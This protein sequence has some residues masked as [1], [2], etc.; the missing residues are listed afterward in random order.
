MNTPFYLKV[1]TPSVLHCHKLP[2][3]CQ[4][5][6]HLCERIGDS[7]IILELPWL[8]RKMFNR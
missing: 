4:N 7:F 1:L 2:V 3:R 8:I 6:C 5:I